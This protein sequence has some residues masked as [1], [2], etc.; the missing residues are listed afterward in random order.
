MYSFNP[1]CLGIVNVLGRVMFQVFITS[2]VLD[3]YKIII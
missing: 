3:Q 2:V 1:M